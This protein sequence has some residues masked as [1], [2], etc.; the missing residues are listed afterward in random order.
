MRHLTMPILYMSILFL[1]GCAGSG[2]T[3]PS[4]NSAL[5][6]VSPNGV[7]KAEK[8]YMQRHYDTWIKEEW[9]P[10]AATKP[11][12]DSTPETTET[13][14]QAVKIE[15]NRENTTDGTLQKY[16]DKWSHYLQTHENESDRAPS[17]VDRLDS[18]PAIGTPRR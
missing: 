6:A 16:V 18:M 9:E 3:P 17:N 1:T 5:G 14:G 2:A 15:K 7:D 10:S 8:G 11:N 12:A 13:L 4:S